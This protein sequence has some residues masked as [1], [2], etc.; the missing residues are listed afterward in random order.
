MAQRVKTYP[1]PKTNKKIAEIHRCFLTRGFM[2]PMNLQP[3]K[4][5]SGEHDSR[6]NLNVKSLKSVLPDFYFLRVAPGA[7][8]GPAIV[9]PGTQWSL[10]RGGRGHR[11]H[12][13]QI[14]HPPK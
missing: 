4:A 11:D 13:S 6:I 5:D 8:A 9:S 12:A 7:P 1:G 3:T 14:A 10:R 2:F